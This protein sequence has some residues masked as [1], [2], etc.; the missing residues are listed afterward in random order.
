MAAMDVKRSLV[1]LRKSDEV[2]QFSVRS[3]ISGAVGN[4][5]FLGAS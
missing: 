4:D 3:K 5:L 2:E 1:R